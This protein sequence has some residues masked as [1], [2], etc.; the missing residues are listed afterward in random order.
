M[1]NRL[2]YMN[3]GTAVAPLAP[4]EEGVWAG[5]ELTA[6]SRPRLGGSGCTTRRGSSLFSQHNALNPSS[7][8]SVLV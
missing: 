7:L 8:A 2:V 5:K 4:R 1:K 3:I 6:Q